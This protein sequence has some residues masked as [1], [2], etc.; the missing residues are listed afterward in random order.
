VLISDRPLPA[1]YPAHCR[2]GFVK[3]ITPDASGE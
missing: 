2:N 3:I 1:D